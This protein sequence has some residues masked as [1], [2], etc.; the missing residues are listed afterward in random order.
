[1]RNHFSKG[2]LERSNPL[3]TESFK[4]AGLSQK[5]TLKKQTLTK[6]SL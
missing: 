4:E 1:M 6:A 2:R 3:P 5:K